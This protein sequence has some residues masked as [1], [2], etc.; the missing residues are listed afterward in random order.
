MTENSDTAT[1]ADLLDFTAEKEEIA[2]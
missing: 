2:I 1:P